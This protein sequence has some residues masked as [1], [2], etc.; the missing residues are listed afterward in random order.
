[1]ADAEDELICDLA[2]TYGVFDYKALPLKTAAAL[3]VGLHD[4]SRAKLKLSGDRY[5]FDRRLQMLIYD[6]LNWLRWAKTRDGAN[7]INIPLPLEELIE[8][9]IQ[10]AQKQEEQRLM[11]FDSPEELNNYIENQRRGGEEVG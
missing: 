8:Q 2:E 10:Q 7:N 4:D 9:N 6:R 11:G 5:G 1:M 3:A